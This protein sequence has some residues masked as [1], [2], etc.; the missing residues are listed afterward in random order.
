MTVS[1]KSTKAQMYSEIERLRALCD[2]QEQQLRAA[3]SAPKPRKGWKRP[4]GTDYAKI[5]PDACK[6]FGKKAVSR[7]EI[8]Q[9]ISE[10]EAA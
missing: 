10:V 6:H 3:K 4:G 7:E 2:R 9:Y 1:M 8:L 5:A